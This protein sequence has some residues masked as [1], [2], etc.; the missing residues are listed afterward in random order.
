M[1]A[2]FAI[3]AGFFAS[4][5]QPVCS[6]AESAAQPGKDLTR[7]L[8]AF[9]GKLQLIH[10]AK[11]IAKAT[12]YY[13][14]Q[15]M[16]LAVQ[17][18]D[19]LRRIMENVITKDEY[20]TLMQA[21][22]NEADADR[23]NAIN[24]ETE[25]KEDSEAKHKKQ[26]IWFKDRRT[27]NDIKKARM[28]MAAHSLGKEED[29]RADE[30][31]AICWIL[32]QAMTERGMAVDE[33]RL[34]AVEAAAVIIRAQ[35][36]HIETIDRNKAKYIKEVKESRLDPLDKATEVLNNLL[37][38][39][40]EE[41]KERRVLSTKAH[42]WSLITKALAVALYRA[43]A[44]SHK[45]GKLMQFTDFE[46]DALLWESFEVGQEHLKELCYYYS[47]ALF[48]IED[49]G[50]RDVEAY[51][52]SGDNT[53]LT[54]KTLQGLARANKASADAEETAKEILA[55][56]NITRRKEIATMA[57]KAEKRREET[58]KL[59]QEKAFMKAKLDAME[60][61][62]KEKNEKIRQAAIR[63]DVDRMMRFTAKK[64]WTRK[65]W[66]D[67]LPPGLE[68]LDRDLPTE[69]RCSF[70]YET[71]STRRVQSCDGR[72]EQR[73]EEED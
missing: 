20:G 18:G 71:K 53:L 62:T 14:L 4:A 73:M 34:K 44:Y 55:C 59:A 35:V 50:R 17:Q 8:I 72:L 52:S 46:R 9:L 37:T 45:K 13:D 67:A 5:G 54:K 38:N 27:D 28:R 22:K 16:T 47:S 69:I 48:Q 7:E 64:K 68:R 40:T 43:N 11:R 42:V 32:C 58:V 26:Q 33:R 25:Q 41:I 21:L 60:K 3:P 10:A 61:E 29:K 65:R 1:E 39:D 66:Q 57:V 2:A 51:R 23:E 70:D 31:E 56:A 12:G 30:R 24:E 49:F 36:R 63:H 15:E 6:D 19:T